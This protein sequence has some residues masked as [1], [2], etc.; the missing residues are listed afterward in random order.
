MKAVECPD[1]D[2][3]PFIS[4]IAM[5]SFALQSSSAFAR[6]L[7]NSPSRLQTP[8]RNGREARST[9]CVNRHQARSSYC[10]CSHCADRT[11]KKEPGL[12]ELEKS[13]EPRLMS[14]GSWYSNPGPLRRQRRYSAAPMHGHPSRM[15]TFTQNPSCQSVGKKEAWGS[16]VRVLS[17]VMQTT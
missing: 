12:D 13:I 10:A 11:K 8:N 14:W 4:P 1:D 6:P 16:R 17:L 5:P 15:P 2:S 3:N 7:N 9:Q